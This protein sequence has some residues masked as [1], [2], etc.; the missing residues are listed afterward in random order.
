[1]MDI[2]EDEKNFDMLLKGIFILFILSL[3]IIA[4]I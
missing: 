4:W 1:M 2:F 3:D